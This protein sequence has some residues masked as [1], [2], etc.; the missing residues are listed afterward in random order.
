M[1]L[2]HHMMM[3]YLRAPPKNQLQA[4]LLM[5]HLRAPPNTQLPQK[6]QLQT[7]MMVGR[8]QIQLGRHLE[9]LYC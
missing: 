2:P 5:V 1:A 8:L 9:P 7:L 3:V 6:N 4:T